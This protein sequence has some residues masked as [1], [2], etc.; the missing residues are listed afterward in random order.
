MADTL[1][2][3]RFPFA[4]FDGKLYEKVMSTKKIIEG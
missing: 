4:E 3:M 2:K 1:Q